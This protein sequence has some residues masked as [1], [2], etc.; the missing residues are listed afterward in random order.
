M[1][2]VAPTHQ[3]WTGSRGL[4]D[5][6]SLACPSFALTVGHE[7]QAVARLEDRIRRGVGFDLCAPPDRECCSAGGASEIEVT[8]GLPGCR[9]F[10]C[11]LYLHETNVLPEVIEKE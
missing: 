6:Q 9:S 3:R 2:L 7:D 8:Q 10:R 11:D 1:D 4:G 5:Q